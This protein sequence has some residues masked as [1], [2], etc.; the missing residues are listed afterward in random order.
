MLR[1]QWIRAFLLNLSS[2]EMLWGALTKD[3]IQSG[4]YFFSLPAL[5]LKQI[6][7]RAFVNVT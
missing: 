6:S 1:K 4:L 2:E 7:K 5:I 3:L